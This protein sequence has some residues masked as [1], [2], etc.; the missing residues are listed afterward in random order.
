MLLMFEEGIR[1]GIFQVSHRYSKAN[2][3]ICKILIK[4]KNQHIFNIL[5][6]IFYMD[7]Q[8]SQSLPVSN[9]K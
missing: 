1:G 6:L 9:F 3:N 7:R 8:G 2:N 5:M 4:I